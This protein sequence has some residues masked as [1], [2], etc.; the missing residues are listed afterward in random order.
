MCIVDNESQGCPQG[1][2]QMILHVHP[3]NIEQTQNGIEG[4][5]II[6]SLL[7]GIGHLHW[8]VMKCFHRA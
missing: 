1:H 8:L 3:I 2:L 5:E 7:K 4:Q 6:M